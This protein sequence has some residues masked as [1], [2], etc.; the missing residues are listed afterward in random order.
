MWT[1]LE[2]M[3]RQLIYMKQS[4]PAFAIRAASHI[5]DLLFELTQPFQTSHSQFVL[6]SYLSTT[7][8]PIL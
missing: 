2:T 7:K 5:C 1:R 3:Y 6:I 8:V 4:F